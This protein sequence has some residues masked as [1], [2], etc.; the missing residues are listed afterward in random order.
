ME[1]VIL[2]Q[3]WLTD[4]F[5]KPFDSGHYGN[6]EVTHAEYTFPRQLLC[7]GLMFQEIPGNMENFKTV[8]TYTDQ[9]KSKTY[10]L[11][12][13]ELFIQLLQDIGGQFRL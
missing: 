8:I 9:N 1:I 10:N 11:L 13:I 5:R 12:L 7:N 2:K 3:E 6:P 4:V